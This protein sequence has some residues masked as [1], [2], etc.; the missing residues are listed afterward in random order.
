[1]TT[2]Y[3]QLQ[4]QFHSL[5]HSQQKV[6]HYIL[7]NMEEMVVL[8]AAKIA[9]ISAVSEAT[10]HRLAQT[11]GCKSFLE[12]KQE[13]HNY[14]C[15]DNRAVKNLMA[16][17]TMQEETWLEQHFVQE[18]DNIILTS[19]SIYKQE[20]N[21]AARKLLEAK[22]IWIGGWRMSLTVTSYMQFVLKYMLGTSQ[23]IPPG[24]IAEYTANFQQKDVLFVCAFPRYDYQIL[25]I[26]EV[27]KRKGMYVIALTDSSLAP[28]CQHADLTLFAKNKS[29]S[30]LDSYTAAVS[31]CNAIINE[32]A[33]IGGERIKTNIADMEDYYA[34][35]N[36]KNK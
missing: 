1:M 22:H 36:P 18:V 31:I 14:N 16:T 30:F 8:S 12:M 11:I 10:V 20:I 9:E 15:A 23:F 13:I 26:V 6:A 33:Y 35:F 3:E 32:I 2:I 19:R 24:E 7:E 17:T 21:Q 28:I 25:K 5:S 29:K 34:M 4:E 27:A